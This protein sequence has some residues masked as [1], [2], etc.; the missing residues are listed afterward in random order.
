MNIILQTR[1][2]PSKKSDSFHY[3]AVSKETIP[4][5]TFERMS[6]RRASTKYRAPQPPCTP[7]SE[8]EDQ[9]IPLM[10]TVS[11]YR[12]QQNMVFDPYNSMCRGCN[13]L[14]LQ[15]QC[16]VLIIFPDSTHTCSTGANPGH[17]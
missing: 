3:K 11:F 2:T 13:L 10:H 4:E 9:Q 1:T 15:W 8:A 12:K 17:S 16:G 6:P 7:S 5:Q 14:L